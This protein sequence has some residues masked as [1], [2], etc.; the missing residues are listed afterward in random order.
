MANI[1]LKSLVKESAL[2]NLP[3]SKLFKYN[4]KTGK[5][6]SPRSI[7]E[8]FK[9]QKLDHDEFDWEFEVNSNKVDSNVYK[10]LNKEKIEFGTSPEG[11]FIMGKGPKEQKH[12]INVL[13]KMGINESALGNLPS[14]KLFKYNKGTGKYDS[15]GS[16]NEAPMDIELQEDIVDVLIL[17]AQISKRIKSYSPKA[18]SKIQSVMKLL[19]Q[20]KK[21]IR[22]AEG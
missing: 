20:A 19:T 2:G 11:M 17:V 3:S 12:A 14:S 4:K 18:F 7:N 13:K 1:N 15:P 5:Y 8:K 9:I 6:N 21:D 10:T 16:V 22:R